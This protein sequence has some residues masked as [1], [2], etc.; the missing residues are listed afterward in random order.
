MSG[1]IDSS[2]AAYLLKEKG[3][4][5]IGITLKLWSANNSPANQCCSFQTANE[6]KIVADFL[7]IPHYTLDCSQEFKKEVVDY[8]LQEYARGKTPNPC[9]RCNQFIKFGLLLSYAKK[10]GT[11]FLATGHYARVEKDPEL[12]LILKKGVDNKKDQSYFLYRLK[13]SSLPYVLFPLGNLYKKEV[14]QIA[15]E[16]GLPISRSQ[17][18]Q[19][20]CFLPKSSFKHLFEKFLPQALKQGPIYNEQEKIIGTHPGIAFFTIGQRKKIGVSSNKPLYVYRIDAKKNAVYVGSREKLLQKELKAKKANW[21][22]SL[23]KITCF[24]AEL[25]IR[26]TT[27]PFK[28]DIYKE[29]NNFKAIFKQPQA[30]ISPGQSAVIYLGETVVGGGVID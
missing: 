1:G 25:K 10:L 18:S 29:N 6:A 20:I 13:K 15:E 28:T 8:F 23:P 22:V 12:G 26:S 24:E 3:F 30:A 14:R 9:I 17:E 16:A 4:E 7:K 11:E 27:P 21:L 19:E 5:V 2:T